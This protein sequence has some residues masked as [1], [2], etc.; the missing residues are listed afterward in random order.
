MY[1]GTRGRFEVQLDRGGVMRLPASGGL[2]PGVRVCV[3]AVQRGEVIEGML[4][5][6]DRC[7]AR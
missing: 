7:S 4:V 3:R 5:A 1:G 2:V 6:M